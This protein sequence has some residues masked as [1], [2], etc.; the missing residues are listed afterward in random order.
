MKKRFDSDTNIKKVTTI[1]CLECEH[2][3]TGACDAQSGGCDAYTPT[4]KITMD[5]DIRLIKT[6]CLSNWILSLGFASAFIIFCIRLI[7]AAL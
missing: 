5:K 3:Y 2:Y 7:I 1:D 6:L 4:R